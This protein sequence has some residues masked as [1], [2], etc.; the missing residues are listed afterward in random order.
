MSNLDYIWSNTDYPYQCL[1]DKFRTNAFRKAIHK[2]IKENSRVIDVGAGSGILSFFAAEA[3]ARKV[4]AV[5]ID[6]FLAS[7]L[8]K[9]IKL[10]K[11]ENKIEV[12]EGDVREVELSEGTDIIIAEIIDTGLLDELQVPVINNL[13]RRGIITAKTEFI[14]NLYKTFLDLVFIDN[15][16]YG[17]QILA[18]KHEWPFFAGK[19]SHYLQTKVVPVSEKLEIASIDFS[20]DFIEENVKKEVFFNIKRDKVVNAIRLSGIV[21]L[22]EGIELGPTYSVNGDKILN[23]DP[24]SGVNQVMMEISYRMGRGLGNLKIEILNAS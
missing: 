4:Y 12:V 23:I 18:P 7:E 13:R 9:S 8:R 2:V 20:S 10:N 14:P 21:Q 17:Y 16:Y 11:L 6:H 19:P 22:C 24:I 1:K 3:G 15:N 5:E